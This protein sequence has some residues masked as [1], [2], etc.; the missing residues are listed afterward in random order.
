VA[1]PR[2]RGGASDLSHDAAPVLHRRRRTSG[3]GAAAAAA[4]PEPARAGSF[5]AIAGV[6]AA[7][8]SWKTVWQWEGNN[9]DGLIAD[10]DGTLL[11]ANNDAS[12]VM[13]LDPATG[14]AEI[15]HADTNTGGAVARGKSG[16]LFLVSRGLN[17]GI[18][19]LEPQR[20]LV[21]SR[22]DG[23]PLE[24]IGGVL[25]DLV[26]DSRD[27]VYVALTGPKGGVF[28]ADPKTGKC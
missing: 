2:P 20:R 25:N 18:L 6:V 24:C 13:R 14:L 22:F 11:F 7:G 5:A 3:A 15:V 8:Q 27:G 4:P 19:Q 12:N 9:A 10:R 17:G 26:V 16:A 28:H 1:G 23:E 21:A